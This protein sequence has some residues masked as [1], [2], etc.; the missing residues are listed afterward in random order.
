M[1]RL[2]GFADGVEEWWHELVTDLKNKTTELGEVGGDAITWVLGGHDALRPDE[3]AVFM[4]DGSHPIDP[5]VADS[6]RA[7]HRAGGQILPVLDTLD[8]ATSKL[9]VGLTG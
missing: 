3:L 1:A 9:P 2:R 4:A 6:L 5:E 8:D 7:H